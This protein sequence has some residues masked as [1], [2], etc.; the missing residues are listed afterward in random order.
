MIYEQ[1]SCEK[2]QKQEAREIFSGSDFWNAWLASLGQTTFRIGGL[3]NN[4][5]TAPKKNGAKFSTYLIL[6]LTGNHTLAD[7]IVQICQKLFVTSDRL[8]HKVRAYSLRPSIAPVL[9]IPRESGSFQ[10]SA[11][12]IFNKLHVAIENISE[13]NSFRHSVKRH[14]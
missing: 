9:S 10:H 8:L 1:R 6:Q 14:S 12:T 5:Q 11:A 13:Y 7:C 2:P 4:L 3:T